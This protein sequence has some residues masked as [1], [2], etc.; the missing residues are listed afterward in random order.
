MAR[1][2]LSEVVTDIRGKVGGTVFQKTRYGHM[3]RTI[4]RGRNKQSFY[5][6]CNR[7]KFQFIVRSW[8]TLTEAQKEAWNNAVSDWTF[9]NV[10]GDTVTP[11]GSLLFN[12]LN[13]NVMN[14]GQ[15]LLTDVPA[16]TVVPETPEVY[17]VID[18]ENEKIFLDLE[19][20]PLNENIYL[21]VEC[22]KPIM[23]GTF[24]AKSKL[25][26][27]NYY[28][29]LGTG[30]IL[31]ITSDYTNRFAGNPFNEDFVIYCRIKLIDKRN[32]LTSVPVIARSLEPQIGILTTQSNEF[33]FTQ[34]EELLLIN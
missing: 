5:Q 28:T 24:N 32:G 25:R 23:D 33:L 21:I 14:V 10:F 1:I 15:S 20:D 7:S 8:R 26:R 30:A 11:T 6:Q 9:E 12:R 22:T 31:D 27:L 29:T 13:L 4:P 34:S 16:V 18:E 3:L 19:T 2:K 17:L